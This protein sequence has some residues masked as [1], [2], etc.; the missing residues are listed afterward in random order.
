MTGLSLPRF[1]TTGQE[2]STLPVLTSAVACGPLQHVG[3]A[4]AEDAAFSTATEATH[5][6]ERNQPEQ[7]LRAAARVVDRTLCRRCPARRGGR[8][9]ARPSFAR[10]V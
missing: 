2:Q 3:T 8:G 4:A 1:K 5:A 7:L 9:M 6:A 10:P